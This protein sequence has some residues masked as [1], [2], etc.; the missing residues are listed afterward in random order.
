M[1]ESWERSLKSPHGSSAGKESKSDWGCVHVAGLNLLSRKT[2]ESNA[3][4]LSVKKPASEQARRPV[5]L[6]ARA[7]KSSL[8]WLLNLFLVRELCSKRAVEACCN[9][10]GIYHGPDEPKKI[11][12]IL[13]GTKDHWI[14]SKEYCGQPGLECSLIPQGT[15]SW[16]CKFCDF[17]H[18]AP[19]SRI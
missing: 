1:K 6:V 14:G 9:P 8:I 17:W 3:L 12:R 11:V 16:K 13:T 5:T 2:M 7:I 4:Q 10:T 19:L 15:G 18:I